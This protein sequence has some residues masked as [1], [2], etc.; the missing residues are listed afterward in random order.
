[1]TLL[2]PAMLWWL[3]VL[4]PLAALYFLKVRPRRKPT[5][6][7]FLWERIFQERRASSLFQ[8]LR[9]V[10]SLVLMM[11]AAAAV[12]FALARPEWTDERK[13][14]LLVIDTS[15]SMATQE[16]RS[17]R[18]DLAI[19]VASE[20]V[21]GLNGNQR[22]AVAT[23]D[24][25]LRYRSHLTDNPRELIDAI[26]SIEPSGATLDL[27]A[28]P[29]GDP[30]REQWTR[31]HR[32][33]FISDG[34]F[35]AADLPPHVELV[36]IG[37]ECDNVGIVA[38]DL[39]YTSGSASRLGFYYQVASSFAELEEI[40][41]ALWQV[42][43]DGHERLFKVIPLQVVP[44]TNAPETFELPQA[45][46][47][48][49]LARLDVKDAL[50]EDN[51][52]YLVVTPPAPI[53]VAVDSSDPFFFENSVQAFSRGDGLLALVRDGEYVG[54]RPTDV[55][56]AKSTTPNAAKAVI[57][58]P[59]GESMW[60]SG[61]GEEV[62]AGSARVLV[63]GHPALR[64]IDAASIPIAGARQLTP[65]VG[66]QVL[67]DDDKGLPIIY[68]ARRDDRTAIIVNMDPAAAEFYFSAWFPVLIHSA[69][70]HLAGRENPL[71]AGYRPGEAV[72]IP[73]GREDVV[74]TVSPPGGKKKVDTLGA[75]FTEGERI[76]F[77]EL[78]NSLGKRDFGVNV[79]SAAESLVNNR[80]T[81]SNHEP[82]SRGRSPAQWLTLLAIVV[83]TAESLLYHRRK[84]G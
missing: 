27:A 33:I 54:Q 63:E 9:D 55:V 30:E 28:L 37:R 52:A 35:E 34:V 80:A 32:V 40:D 51:T 53:R 39:A 57:F 26:A 47:G 15:A 8:R 59:V 74:T 50:A 60:W 68:K 6:A 10:W 20:I 62:A 24:N 73:G 7:Y 58:Q 23:I 72:P 21:E 44:G 84:V 65:P 45:P 19:N 76:G 70:T 31:D 25:R 75:W 2:Q 42:D 3:L 41:L 5:T 1:M 71:A 13:D 56:L 49:W 81:R 46:A 14:F 61:L 77:Y 83:L 69:A 67:V 11:L 29:G 36:K 66:A 4:A 64:H 17:S 16:D 78:A 12:C 82:L 22:G 79:F 38:A 43:E 48:R 18:L